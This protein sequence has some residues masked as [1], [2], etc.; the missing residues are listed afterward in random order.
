MFRAAVV[1]VINK[2]DL[3]PHLDFDLAIFLAN[4]DAVNPGMLTIE[5]SA[6]RGT[7]CRRSV[8]G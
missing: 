5:A 2:L 7:A 4:L 1:V 8:S 6:G 3:L